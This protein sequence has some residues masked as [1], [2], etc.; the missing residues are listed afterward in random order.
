MKV[1]YILNVV[2]ATYVTGKHVRSKK[3]SP[4]IKKSPR[5]PPNHVDSYALNGISEGPLEDPSLISQYSDSFFRQGEIDSGFLSTGC[6]N[7]D[8]FLYNNNDKMTCRWIRWKE[9]RRISLCEDVSVRINCPQTCGLCCEDD[10][11]YQFKVNGF[12]SFDCVSIAEEIEH[13]DEICNSYSNRRM[14][15]D[16]CPVTCNFC[17]EF[18]PEHIPTNTPSIVSTRSVTNHDLIVFYSVS[19]F[20]SHF[21]ILNHFQHALLYLVVICLIQ[22]VWIIHPIKVH[23]VA[24]VVARSLKQPTV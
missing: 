11:N 18:V 5:A 1:Q 4:S 7:N 17:Q 21:E 24:I 2:A 6:F 16:G 12:N 10:L 19:Q 14:V 23:L 15:R 20:V 8:L 3:K 9:D 22:P 13:R